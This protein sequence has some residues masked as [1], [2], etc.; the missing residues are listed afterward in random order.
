M[1][2]IISYGLVATTASFVTSALTGVGFFHAVL[3]GPLAA[4]GTLILW[5]LGVLAADR[6]YRPIMDA[7]F[8]QRDVC[9]A[10]SVF[11]SIREVTSADP[12]SRCAECMACRERFVIRMVRGMI[13]ATRLGKPAD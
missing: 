7:G 8:I 4:S 11:G 9:P 10:C 3:V 6:T 12:D 13:R 2:K 5:G 1:L